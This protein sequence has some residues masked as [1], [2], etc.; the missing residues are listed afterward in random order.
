MYQGIELTC[1]MHCR[2]EKKIGKIEPREFIQD[3]HDILISHK[4]NAS[5]VLGIIAM[6]L[7]IYLF[8]RSLDSR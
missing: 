6:L 3:L 1:L 4:V 2:L 8:Q 7:L 5:G